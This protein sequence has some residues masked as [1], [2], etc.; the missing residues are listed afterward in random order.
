MNLIGAKLVR[1]EC[2][3]WP[4]GPQ[5]RDVLHYPTVYAW[6]GF[7]G[8]LQ[9][10]VREFD[11]SRTRDGSQFRRTTRDL[12]NCLLPE[13]E[14]PMGKQ[15]KIRVQR[16]WVLILNLIGRRLLRISRIRSIR[17]RT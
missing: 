16:T 13:E 10:I 12:Y 17:K 1:L 4:G 14:S 8:Q 9:D 3:G 6:S 7:E 15:N 5:I 11:S 2:E